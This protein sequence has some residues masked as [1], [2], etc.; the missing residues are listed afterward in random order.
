ML[1]LKSNNSPINERNRLGIEKL[2]EASYK[3]GEVYTINERKYFCIDYNNIKF[4]YLINTNKVFQIGSNHKSIYARIF[5]SKIPEQFQSFW[6]KPIPTSTIMKHPTKEIELE[7][8]SLK[9]S[10]TFNYEYFVFQKHSDG[11]ATPIILKQEYNPQEYNNHFHLWFDRKNNVKYQFLMYATNLSESVGG[12]I[13][14][15]IF[16]EYLFY[17]YV[18]KDLSRIPKSN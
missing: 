8:V 16:T 12:K 3:S 13:E 7:L 5:K 9:I 1:T 4:L 17:Y 2:N 15:S 18:S 6:I 11:T 10:K 14:S